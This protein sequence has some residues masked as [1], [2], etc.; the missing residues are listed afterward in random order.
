MYNTNIYKKMVYCNN[1][2]LC[3]DIMRGKYQKLITSVSIF[4]IF[5]LVLTSFILFSRGVSSQLEYST[6]Q[7]LGE[8]SG[9]QQFTFNSELVNERNALNSIAETLVIM[10]NNEDQIVEYLNSLIEH[11]GFAALIVSDLSGIG[12]H[13]SGEIVDISKQSYFSAALQGEFILSEP[14][15][16]VSSDDVV[17]TAA[18]PIYE[19]GEIAGVVATEYTDAYLRAFLSEA[20]DGASYTVVVNQEGVIMLES[21]P[22]HGVGATLENILVSAT[23]ENNRSVDEVQ[24]DILEGESGAVEYTYD[25]VAKLCDYRPVELNNWSIITIVPI[26]VIDETMNSILFSMLKVALVIFICFLLFLAYLLYLE[27]KNYKTIEQLAY[28]DDLTG[29]YNVSKLKI[30]AQKQLLNN[31]NTAFVMVKFDF[32]NFKTIN[33]LFSFKKGDELLKTAKKVS[34]TIQDPSFIIARVGT[35][36]FMFFGKLSLFENFEVQHFYFEQMYRDMIE[37]LGNYQLAFRYGRYIIPKGST[38]IIEIVNRVNLAHSNTKIDG[39]GLFCDYD[40]NYTSKL[41]RETEITNKMNDAL[42]GNEF[43]VYLQPKFSVQEKRLVGAEALVRWEE[44]DGNM[45]FPGDFIPL[46]EKNGFIAKLDKY[47]LEQT[48]KLIQNWHSQGYGHLKISVNLSRRNLSNPTIIEEIVSVV[49]TYKVPHEYVEIELTESVAIENEEALSKFFSE[50][51]RNGIKTSIDDFG[52]GYS[53]LSMLKTLHVDTLKMDR[54]F[55]VG[56]ELALR[57][58]RL[59]DGIVKLSHSMGLYVVAEGIET[60]DQIEILKAV[61]C[62][63][64]QGYFYSKPLPACE[65]EKKYLQS[66]TNSQ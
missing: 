62:D 55:F 33:E 57:S 10:G 45:L 34:D 19:N 40:E 17:L 7:T 37:D 6:A 20:F 18:A 47:V 28:F 35:D 48:C 42:A 5:A 31:P 25:G 58:D 52:V 32:V 24:Q 16:A 8:I 29:M 54:S 61:K 49:D 15:P 9:Q 14:G 51:H 1:F 30:E 4:L 43:K 63:A 53:S 44:K 39:Y 22:V 2:T 50:L 41:L 11:H 60:S 3:G 23:I 66:T 27:R 38:D 59:I 13:S 56:G 26:E 36:E 64:V 21:A 65:F 46:F 12:V